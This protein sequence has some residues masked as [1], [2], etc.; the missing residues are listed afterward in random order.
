MPL[1]L[2][3]PSP[4]E[5]RVRLVSPIAAAANASQTPRDRIVVTGPLPG[6]AVIY[7]CDGVIRGRS[8]LIPGAPEVAVGPS[9]ISDPAGVV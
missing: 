6:P 8:P 9:I 3:V 4:A 1:H 2:P 5:L 7:E